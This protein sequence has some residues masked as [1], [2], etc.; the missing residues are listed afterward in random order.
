MLEE[1]RVTPQCPN[2]QNGARSE[3]QGQHGCIGLSLAE[4]QTSTL[5][6][7]LESGRR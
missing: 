7:E 2:A 6:D 1:S 3:N 4:N 5:E